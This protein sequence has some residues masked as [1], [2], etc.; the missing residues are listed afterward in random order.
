MDILKEAISIFDGA[1]NFLET[2]NYYFEKHNCGKN[3]ENIKV[4]LD[5]SIVNETTDKIIR[6]GYC[7]RCRTVFYHRDFVSK[8]L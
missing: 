1:E 2:K 6:F 7:D 8:R 4:L 3:G 5:F